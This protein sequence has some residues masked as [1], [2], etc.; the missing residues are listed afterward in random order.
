MV[1]K[2]DEDLTEIKNILGEKSR[3]IQCDVCQR[4]M[5]SFR[6]LNHHLRNFHEI[7]DY[8]TQTNTK[9]FDYQI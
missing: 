8:Q 6:H 1:E 4:E 7:F 5:M 3:R 2:M 9:S